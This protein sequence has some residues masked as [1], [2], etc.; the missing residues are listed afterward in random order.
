MRKINLGN[1]GVRAMAPRSRAGMR[2][3][4][5]RFPREVR[6]NLLRLVQL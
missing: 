3:S 5:P 2:R 4:V 1:N 6:T